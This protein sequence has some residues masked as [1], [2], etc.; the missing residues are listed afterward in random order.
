MTA[1]TAEVGICFL[2]N[3][4]LNEEDEKVTVSRCIAAS[5]TGQ[6][7]YMQLADSDKKQL[8]RKNPA[9]IKNRSRIDQN[10]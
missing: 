1:P 5:Y 2:A 10:R 3:G 6:L 7:H 9:R 8:R 4:K